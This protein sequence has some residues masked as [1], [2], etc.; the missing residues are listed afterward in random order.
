M[1]VELHGA[2]RQV[3]SGITVLI[4]GSE[5]HVCI[6]QTTLCLRDLGFGVQIVAD[7]TTAREQLYIDVGNARC[8]QLGAKITTG[9]MVLLEMLKDCCDPRWRKLFKIFKECT[10]NTGSTPT[11]PAVSPSPNLSHE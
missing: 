9:E 8:V 3:S 1:I 7:A 4:A 11:A 6:Y 5:N 2:L 10:H